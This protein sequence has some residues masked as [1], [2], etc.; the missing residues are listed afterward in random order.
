[1]NPNETQ[2][3]LRAA[4]SRVSALKSIGRDDE[5]IANALLGLKNMPDDVKSIMKNAKAEGKASSIIGGLSSLNIPETND[6]PSTDDDFKIDSGVGK[7]ARFLGIEKA[8]RR[9]GSELAKFSG[10]HRENLAGLGEE[11]SRRIGTGGVSNREFVGSLGNVALNVAMPFG[12]KALSALGKGGKVA[13]TL[14]S[15]SGKAKVARGIG[16]GSAFG[17][18]GGLNEGQEGGELVRSAFGGALGGTF[19]T[20]GG[21]ALG[22]LKQGLKNFRSELAGI[23]PQIAGE[24]KA[25]PNDI[26]F[27]K[28]V[29]SVKERSAEGGLRKSSPIGVAAQELEDAGT[30]IQKQI[31]KAGKKV[32][33]VKKSVAK[34][35][36]GEIA[37]VIDEFAEDAAEK[38]GI[39]ITR[40]KRGKVVINKV[41]G[42]LRDI[43]PTDQKRIADI[44]T[45]LNKLRNKG[46]LGKASDVMNNLDDLVDYSKASPFGKS[47]DP[48]EALIK[49]TRGKLN[50]KA[51]AVSTKFASAN[52][53]FAR[54]KD[55]EKFIG[56]T[57]GKD[58]QRGA[59]LIRRVFSGDKSD[60]ALDVFNQ[61]K[62]A[63]GKDLVEDAVLA[64]F[65]TDTM[66]DKTS[67]TL[68]AQMLEGGAERIK[69]RDL[70]GLIIDAGKKV[71]GAR[72][73]PEKKA[74]SLINT[75]GKGA[76]F[77]TRERQGT[78][79][80]VGQAGFNTL[81]RTLGN[82]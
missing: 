45:Q 25:M 81:S 8:G 40:G 42:S 54:L 78:R 2:N 33:K 24:L 31:K 34:E 39:S 60:E 36:L 57:A 10:S 21:V 28:Y 71:A 55:L 14:A 62:K 23:S 7:V 35:S 52:D 4:K 46:T 6:A 50:G 37:D 9:I 72:V 58:L 22:K 13:R 30:I 11:E 12:G 69:S 19:F 38:F 76:G 20:G 27:N 64:K 5:Y 48:L 16:T 53:E 63:T 75:A 18:T 43:S 74:R 82:F 1:M 44:Y 26:K 41:A 59:L 15:T 80:T 66:G 77:L 79:R 70:T 68:L 73:N 17:V 67:K 29:K 32:G 56:K 65:V 47:N 49:T 3:F 51:R 61:I